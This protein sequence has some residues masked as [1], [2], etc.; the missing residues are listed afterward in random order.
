M[1]WKWVFSLQWSSVYLYTSF[2]YY[3]ITLFVSVWNIHSVLRTHISSDLCQPLRYII[4][5]QW[6]YF[7]RLCNLFILQWYACT[8][9]R[10]VT[11]QRVIRMSQQYLHGL[12]PR[13]VVGQLQHLFMLASSVHQKDLPQCYVLVVGDTYICRSGATGS[14]VRHEI[15]P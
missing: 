7:S 6:H 12:E 5:F 9:G 13:P 4:I 1:F 10:R 2:L 14:V 3:F 8:Q 15:S 11:T